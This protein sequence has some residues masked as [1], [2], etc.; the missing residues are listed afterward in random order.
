MPN[1]NILFQNMPGPSL[2]ENFESALGTQQKLNEFRNQPMKNR[3]LQ[4]EV[5]ASDINLQQAQR[6][7]GLQE[8]DQQRKQYLQQ[9]GDMA[10]DAVGLLP[11]I[12]AGDVGQI[13][14]ALDKRIEKIRARGGDPSDTMDFRDR[15]LSGQINK[16]QAVQELSSV[17]STAE[18]IGLMKPVE[19]TKEEG[20][21]LGKGQ[22]RYDAKGNLIASGQPD[23]ET[24]VDRAQAEKYLAEA[25]K[26]RTET[27]AIGSQSDDLTPLLVNMSPGLA[28][29]ASSAYQLAG[30]GKDG[31]KA[32]MAVA[33]QGSEMERRE[34]AP[35]ILKN[36]FKDATPE[37]LTQLQAAVDS[38]KDTE[39]G[40][41]AAAEVREKQ[42]NLKKYDDYRTRATGLI[43]RILNN[44]ELEDVLGSFEGT[45]EAW[46]SDKEAQAIADIEE[47]SNILTADNLDL[48][49][50]VLSNSDIQMLK[51]ISS[52]ATNRKKGEKQFAQDMAYLK[53]KLLSVNGSVNGQGEIDDL[54]SKYAD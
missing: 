9:I 15:L 54:V 43:D 51:S 11:L 23:E 30:G 29:K 5:A 21:T 46:V 27:N 10:V 45:G 25:E 2:S 33:E 35:A 1:P 13:T 44:D 17:V 39:S 26:L 48:M 42:R 49:K 38:A 34:L 3:L 6:E 8:Q 50:G 40:F 16:D 18:R 20:F 37:E 47:L 12:E 41:K 52:G 53:N 14:T 4:N 32:L 31:V 19:K 36:R 24:E 28:E 7:V 22:T